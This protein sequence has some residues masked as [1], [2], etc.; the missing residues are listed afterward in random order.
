M[1]RASVVGATGYAGEE[2]VRILS[3]HPNFTL[4]HLVSHSFVGQK[5]EDVYMNYKGS[6]TIVLEDLDV[7]KIAA[8]SDVVFTSLPHGTS[9]E[10]IPSFVETG[11]KVV[12]FSG[13]YRYED[14]AVYEAWYGVKHPRPE[15]LAQS[16]Y[17]LPELHRDAIRKAQLIGNPGCYTT[18]SILALAPLVKAGILDTRTIFIDAKSGVTGAGRNPSQ[19]LHFCE[20][21]ESMKAYN[22][23]KHR[24]TSEIEQELSLQAGSPIAL[25]FT[26]HLVPL[27]R[28]IL[29]TSYALLAK[30]VTNEDVAALYEEAYG[31]EPFVCVHPAGKLPELKFVRGSNFCHIGFVIDTRLHRIVVVSVIDNLVK[32][33]A[34]QAVQNANILFGLDETTGLTMVPWYL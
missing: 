9:N 32:G 4:A 22:V 13:D 17:G 18:C 27:Q 2:L 20:V 24:H 21:N 10:V 8:D 12:D 33:A 11:V 3:S 16:V 28:G 15:L 1:I 34:G 31:N 26:P 30:D 23:A 14:P 5:L 19:A 7:A 6:E 29:A 25:S